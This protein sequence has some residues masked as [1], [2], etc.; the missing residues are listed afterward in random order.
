MF[1][2][3]TL[4]GLPIFSQPQEIFGEDIESQLPVHHQYRP[5]RQEGSKFH[6]PRH[7]EEYVELQK[8]ESDI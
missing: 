1:L 8:R 3:E 2:K 4:L 6:Q 5:H 7:R